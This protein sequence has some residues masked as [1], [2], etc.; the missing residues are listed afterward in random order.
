MATA[1]QLLAS[2]SEID[3]TLIIDS[4]LRTIIIPSSVKNLGVVSDDDV[5]KLDFKMPGEY[6]GIDLSKFSTRI[7]YLNANGEGDVYDVRDTELLSD[8]MIHFTW[9]VGRHATTYKGSV[10]FNICLKDAD[11]EG[12]VLREFNTTIASL[13]VLE[14]LET[15]E[16][17]VAQYSDIFEQWRNALFGLV[18]SEEVRLR[19]VS[20]EEQAAIAAEG[21]KQ[22]AAVADKGVETLATIPEDYTTTYNA[23]EEALRTKADAI[24]LNAKGESIILQDASNGFVQNLKLYGR[25]DQLKTTGK[26]LFAVTETIANSGISWADNTQTLNIDSGEYSA[27]IPL[28]ILDT[29]IEAGTKVTFTI[30]TDAG[31]IENKGVMTLGGYHHDDPG[32]TSWQ[33]ELTLPQGVDLTGG[34]YTRTF[35]TT[36]TINRFVLF[37]NAVTKIGS[38]I[39]LRAQFELGDSSTEYEFYSSGV[40]TPNPNDPQG[41]F[42]VETPTVEIYGANLFDM[43]KI[44]PTNS[45]TVNNDGTLTVSLYSNTTGKTLRKLAPGLRIG[46]RYTLFLDTDGHNYIYLLNPKATWNSGTTKIMTEDM[47]ESTFYVYGKMDDTP[48]N[49]RLISIV[50]EELKTIEYEPFKTPKSVSVPY[51][52]KGVPVET[53]G[54]Y[55]DSNG[56]QWICDE[57]DFGRG[58]YIQRCFDEVRPFKYDEMNDRWNTTLSH[59]AD[60]NCRVKDGIPLLCDKLT[61]DPTVRSGV[62]GI[63][64]ASSSPLYA[65]AYYNGQDL[66]DLRLIYPLETP[67][68]TQLT[69]AEIQAY[70]ALRTN[71]PN[72]FVINDSKMYMDLDYAVDTHMYIDNLIAATSQIKST[73]VTLAANKWAETQAVYYQIVQ[74]NGVSPNSKI[75]IQLSPDQILEFMADD[76]SLTT[77]N[78]NGTVTIYAI[79]NKPTYDL[80]IQVLITEVI[81][82]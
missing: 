63:R 14:G 57:V 33:C 39:K 55:T 1:D 18:D 13:D 66:G 23:A 71:H 47:L 36:A 74:M 22:V 79:G 59:R 24:V 11:S 31:Y 16:A 53:N 75:D 78:N 41:L 73:S 82:V 38:A 69:A 35:T 40:A 37:L 9:L 61:F 67:I 34:V 80:T 45:I 8:G 48:S 21:S 25:T 42:S 26:N 56:Q 54:N 4:D 76:I 65:I 6:C 20:K 19:N 28:R 64:I 72:T 60:P 77:S 5:L 7:N 32:V 52:L 43:S 27:V 49:I 62:N 29:P 2:V 70:K 50:P 81:P 12:V 58:V 51:A 46:E 15:D 10:K 17:V 3:K 68:E 44:T 30:Y